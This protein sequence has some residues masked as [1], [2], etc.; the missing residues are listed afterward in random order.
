LSVET[1]QERFFGIPRAR[2]TVHCD[3]CRS[4]LRETGYRQWR[5]AV[6]P[7]VNQAMYERYNGQALDEDTLAKLAE[8][9]L[10]GATAAKPRAPFEP[11]T[12]V[13]HDDH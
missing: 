2:R 7:V 6:D 5:Y 8:K 10:T 12:F 11:P 13:D 3:H 1:R 9:P 4:V